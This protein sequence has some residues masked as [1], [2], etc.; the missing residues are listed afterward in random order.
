MIVPTFMDLSPALTN[1]TQTACAWINL[2]VSLQILV[3]SWDIISQCRREFHKGRHYPTIYPTYP[4]ILSTWQRIAEKSS[5]LSNVIFQI[6]ILWVTNV[7][8][9]QG[10]YK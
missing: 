2:Y 10:L 4:Q 3:C 1:I 9:S 8:F 7:L 5:D 6:H